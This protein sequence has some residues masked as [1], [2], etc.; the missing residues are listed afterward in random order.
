MNAELL[1]NSVD[2]LIMLRSELQGSVED[3]VIEK[4]DEVVNH[5]K[6]L[7]QH[8]DEISAHDVLYILGAILENVPVI[9][10]LIHLLTTLLK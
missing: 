3:S 5:L 6:A 2:A 7:Q 8:P 1:R 9:V 10:E 4:L